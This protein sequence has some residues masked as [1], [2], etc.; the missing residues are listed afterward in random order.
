[1][2]Q[3]KLT[4]KELIGIGFKECKSE[5]DKMNEAKTYFKLET[6]NGYFYYNP[7]QK[8]YTWYHKTI[9]GNLNNDIHLDISKRPE[10]F[11]LL[12]CFNAKFNLVF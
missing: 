12:R 1:M 11:V 3:L 8:R 7:K 4:D 10:L 2:N 9:I 6:I 5:A